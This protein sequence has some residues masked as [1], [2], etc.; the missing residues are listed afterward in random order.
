MNSEFSGDIDV[1]FAFNSSRS[2]VI[3]IDPNL[4]LF[5]SLVNLELTPMTNSENAVES[6]WTVYLSYQLT[7]LDRFPVDSSGAECDPYRYWARY[8]S[9][10]CEIKAGMQ[11]M[12]YGHCR[13]LRPLQL[14]DTINPNDYTKKTPGTK[15]LVFKGYPRNDIQS[16]MWM[17]H[18]DTTTRDSHYGGRINKVL[19]GIE[20]AFTY[21][22]WEEDG[23][24]LK[25]RIYGF[26]MFADVEIGLWLEHATHKMDSLSDYNQTAFGA[27]YTFPNCLN[28]LHLSIEHML[29]TDGSYRTIT[30]STAMFFDTQL[31]DEDT[32]FASF[33]Y[34]QTL[35]MKSVNLRINR[36]LSDT[37]T[38]VL[39]LDWS[40]TDID[41]IYYEY[42]RLVP[43][44]KGISIRFVYSF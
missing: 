26:D 20:L 17:V 25:E 23:E 22:H 3:D 41:D 24:R 27:D 1:A 9:E 37:T 8:V 14:F 42:N 21:H 15:A 4:Y 29:T 40:N 13:Y 34:E 39:S 10:T 38:G 31:N 32:L 43:I 5:S 11:K 18:N 19:E 35:E 44:Q 2:N 28:G 30:N 33:L 12:A 7:A 36:D 16:Y 6:P